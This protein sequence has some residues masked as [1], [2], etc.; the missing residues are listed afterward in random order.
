M[1]NKEHSFYRENGRC[2]KF[3][4]GST[5]YKF[6]SSKAR[7]WKKQ[8]K[9]TNKTFLWEM[10]PNIGVTELFTR[11][12]FFECYQYVKCQN[13]SRLGLIPRSGLALVIL[14]LVLSDKEVPRLWSRENV[15]RKLC[16]LFVFGSTHWQNQ[17]LPPIVSRPCSPPG[18]PGHVLL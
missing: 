7:T 10:A 12:S 2:S 1:L 13:L 4:A 3:G 15:T 9:S 6:K 18:G 11:I 14:R 8:Q 5:K 17:T 16:S